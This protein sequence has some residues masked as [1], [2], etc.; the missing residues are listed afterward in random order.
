MAK[1]Y[2][3]VAIGDIVMDAFIRLQIADEHMDHATREICMPF[4]TN[5]PF[6]F[7]VEVPA[8]G[9]CANAAVAAARLGLS[10]AL[11]TNQGDDETGIKNLKRLTDEHVATD[12]VKVWQGKKS[13]YHYVLWYRDERTILVKHEEYP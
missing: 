13:N 12:F 5:I 4:A 7:V 2:D 9:N 10:S 1:Q 3:F 11:I 8:V 6:E